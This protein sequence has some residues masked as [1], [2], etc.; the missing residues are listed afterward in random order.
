ME[1]DDDGSGRGEGGGGPGPV[2]EDMDEEQFVEEEQVVEEQDDDELDPSNRST[3][4]AVFAHLADPPAR[5]C[6]WS[7]AGSTAH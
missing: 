4:I 5:S 7:F 1:P 2:S 6:P 3:W